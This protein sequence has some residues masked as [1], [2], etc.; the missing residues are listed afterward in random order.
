M[1]KCKDCGYSD[2][3][4]FSTCPNCDSDKIEDVA[5]ESAE[6]QSSADIC[7]DTECSVCAYGHIC[8]GTN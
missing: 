7:D 4:E 3:R 1:Y 5:S 6:I 2:D 8:D